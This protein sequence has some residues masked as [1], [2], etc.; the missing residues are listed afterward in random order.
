MIDFKELLVVAG[1]EVAA[2]GCELPVE[3]D[4][5]GQRTQALRDTAVD[6]GEGASAVAF[7]A[8]LAF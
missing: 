3:P 2:R 7:E 6:P 5:C 1:D 8:E 4:R